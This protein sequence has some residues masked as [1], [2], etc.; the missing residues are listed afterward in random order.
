MITDNAEPRIHLLFVRRSD[1][2]VVCSA[3]VFEAGQS[4]TEPRQK[5]AYDRIRPLALRRH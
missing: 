4:G 3:P 5:S 2:A 1:G